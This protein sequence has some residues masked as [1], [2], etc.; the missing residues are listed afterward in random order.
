MQ[1]KR[2]FIQVCPYFTPAAVK[3]QPRRAAR[4]GA[5]VRLHKVSAVAARF[6]CMTVPGLVFGSPCKKRKNLVYL[7]QLVY[8]IRVKANN[9]EGAVC[10]ILWSKERP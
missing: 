3:M 9:E 6:F 5:F 2:I 4:G 1:F 7:I 8:F 10:P